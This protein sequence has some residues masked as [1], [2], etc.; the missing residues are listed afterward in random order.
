MNSKNLHSMVKVFGL[1]LV[2]PL[3]IA[4]CAQPEAPT[5][6]A[7]PE[8]EVPAPVVTE[9]ASPGQ[10]IGIASVPNLRDV[11]G[12]QTSDGAAIVK[13]LV[14]RSNQLSGITSED[15]E[16]IA[17][18]GL[19]IDYDLRTSDE[20]DARPDELPEGVEYVWLDVLADSPQAGPAMLEKLME[21]PEEANAALGGGKAAEG[22][23]ESY[24]EFVSLPSAKAEFS[25]LFVG[26]GDEAQLPALFH[27]TTGK[28]RT[29]WAA[30]ALLT[31]LGV[32][33]ET[34][35]EDYLRSNDYIIPMYQE[36]ID[37][38]VAAGGEEGIPTSILGVRR[39]YLEAAFDEMETQFGTIEN[40]FAEGLGIDAEQQDAIRMV[41]LRGQ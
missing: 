30:A 12:Y 4:G 16:A 34:I 40:Y 24:R 19:K 25:K 18:L 22:F 21:N 5:E 31:L 39:E 10:S 2:A 35:M 3:L 33:T 23:A 15:M 11:G 26:L 41:Y 9:S 28:D 8:E 20:K 6:T 29:G 14:Y 38:F 27:C 7:D 36:A 37:A 17:A 32:P 13:G 1:L